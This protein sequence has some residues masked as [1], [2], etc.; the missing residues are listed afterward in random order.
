MGVSVSGRE[1]RH[2]RWPCAFA[3]ALKS[4]GDLVTWGQDWGGVSMLSDWQSH[5]SEE[6]LEIHLGSVTSGE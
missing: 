2:V 5:G 4:V 6:L 3:A 1:A